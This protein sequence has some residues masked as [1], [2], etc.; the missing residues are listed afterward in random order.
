MNSSQFLCVV[1]PPAL[2]YLPSSSSSRMSLAGCLCIA[3]TY[4][5]SPSLHKLACRGPRIVHFLVLREKLSCHICGV[6]GLL[7]FVF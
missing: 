3:S 1:R 2:L 4:T 5:Q 6:S 7:E